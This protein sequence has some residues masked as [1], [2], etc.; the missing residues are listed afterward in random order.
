[1][2]LFSQ[3]R[4]QPLIVLLALRCIVFEGFSSS[5]EFSYEKFVW[6]GRSQGSHVAVRD[7]SGSSA[8]NSHNAVWVSNPVN[9]LKTTEVTYDMR[10]SGCNLCP[11]EIYRFFTVEQACPL[12]IY[13]QTISKLMINFK[14]QKVFRKDFF[15]FI[16][17][18]MPW[19]HRFIA[20]QN[21][22][23]VR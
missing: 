15:K 23:K 2:K 9:P 6:N 5:E 19:P 20:Q 7:F 10:T 8:V 13:F 17:F 12:Q 4:R 14:K 18:F 11:I 3:T 21:V 16:N 1:M 22:L